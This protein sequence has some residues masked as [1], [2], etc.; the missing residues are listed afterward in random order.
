MTGDEDA[1]EKDA[2]EEDVVAKEAASNDAVAQDPTEEDATAAADAS[3]LPET[4]GDLAEPSDDADAVEEVIL[5]AETP[6]VRRLR[7]GGRSGRRRCRCTFSLLQ[8]GDARVG[9][10]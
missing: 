5:S 4:P 10:M 6:M 2:A 9:G 8:W 1:V 3:E 7:R